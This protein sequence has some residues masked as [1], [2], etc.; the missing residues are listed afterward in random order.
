MSASQCTVTKVRRVAGKLSVLSPS[1]RTTL[2]DRQAR[3]VCRTLLVIWKQGMSRLCIETLGQ[4]SLPKW[5]IL[6]Q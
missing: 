5:A 6:G 3:L 4:D 1:A 2:A